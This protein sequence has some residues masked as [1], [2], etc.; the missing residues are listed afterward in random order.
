MTEII[1]RGISQENWPEHFRCDRERQQI[2]RGRN[3]VF[4]VFEAKV[5]VDN[6]HARFFAIFQGSR[7]MEWVC[8]DINTHFFWFVN[9][10]PPAPWTGE[11]DE[12][13]IKTYIDSTKEAALNTKLLRIENLALAL[14]VPG[15]LSLD[16]GI[17]DSA[18]SC[19]RED[20][21]AR[22]GL[23]NALRAHC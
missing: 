11:D 6:R 12:A 10:G 1:Q 13:I 5:V 14:C 8:F 17:V 2:I 21:T 19:L 3:H 20:V 16:P 15:F 22:T 4:E 9:G 18:L 7:V 23:S